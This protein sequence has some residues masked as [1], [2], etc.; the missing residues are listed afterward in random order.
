MMRGRMRVGTRR[1]PGPREH[2]L[3]LMGLE[4]ADRAQFSGKEKTLRVR[5]E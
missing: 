4:Q 1:E 3:F 2:F 5:S